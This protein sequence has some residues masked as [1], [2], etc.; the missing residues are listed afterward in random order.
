MLDEFHEDA[1]PRI[2]QVID[3]VM[4]TLKNQF[5]HNE[6][7]Q[8]KQHTTTTPSDECPSDPATSQATSTPKKHTYTHQALLGAYTPI[9]TYAPYPPLHLGSPLYGNHLMGAHAHPYSQIGN[10]GRALP[11]NHPDNKG[12]QKKNK[13]KKK[14]AQKD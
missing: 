4:A 3:T 7:E 5:G 14:P 12:K 9:N 11:Q 13:Q 10:S 8:R 1:L 2:H 6:Y